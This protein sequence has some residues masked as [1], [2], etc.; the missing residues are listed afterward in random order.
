MIRKILKAYK[1]TGGRMDQHFLV[2]ARTLDRIVD[3]AELTKDDVVLEIGGGIG[4]LSERIA[5]QAGMLYIIEKDPKMVDVLTHRLLES[6]D[7]AFPGNALGGFGF[8]N[9]V[10]IPGDVME[11]DLSAVPFNKIVANLPYSISS[12]VTFRILEQKFDMAVLMYQYEFAKRLEA[13]AGSKDYGRLSVHAQYRAKAEILFDVPKSFFEP[14]PEVDSA[15]IRLIPGPAGYEVRDV[16]YFLRVTQALFS[17]RRK[18]VKNTLINNRMMIGIPEL[19]E[20]LSDLCPEDITE[21]E[22]IA[23][24]D[25]R[26][27]ELPPEKIA[28]LAGFLYDKREE[29]KNDK[30]Q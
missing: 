26:P 7:G 2:D 17:Q 9:V 8:K 27:E 6:S 23:M 10:I 18:K 16:P 11:T 22:I 3:A 28:F 14:A 4:N 30:A 24:M 13:S 1:V 5:R 21:S 20:I 12:D 19:K 25:K 29:R 15:V